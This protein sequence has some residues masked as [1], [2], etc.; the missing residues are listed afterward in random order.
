MKSYQKIIVALVAGAAVGGAAIQSI[1]AQAKTAYVIVAIRSV[2]D[3]DNYKTVTEQA[4]A[5]VA[6]AG[7]RL[8]VATNAIT[9]LDGKP[10][11]RFVLI[12]FDSAAKAQAWYDSPAMKEINAMRIKSTDSLSFIVEG[13]GN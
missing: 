3:A 4:P 2:V 13:T 1:H 10:P 8:V 11:Q 12:A 6:A 5:V 9:S 7:G